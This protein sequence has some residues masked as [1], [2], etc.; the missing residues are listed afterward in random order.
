MTNIIYLRD[1]GPPVVTINSPS[2]SISSSSVAFNITLSENGDTAIFTLDNWS[3]NYTLQ[4]NGFRDF[5]YTNSSMSDGS[6]TVRFYVNDSYGNVNNTA[7]RD[8]T[9]D[10]STPA[11]ASSGGSGGGGGGGGAT[12]SGLIYV[13]S[14]G[15]LN[16]G[17]TR[18]IKINDK[19]KFTNL[20]EEHHV[21]LD[22]VS[23]DSISGGPHVCR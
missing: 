12:I 21:S 11:P 4:A 22:S 16:S 15:N 8:F 1:I 3:S 10:T 2:A 5:N 13:I 17:Y 19:F 23:E 20:N 9:I 18:E 14:D 6:Y 7:S